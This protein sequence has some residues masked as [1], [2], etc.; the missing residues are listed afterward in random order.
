MQRLLNLIKRDI[1]HKKFM[2]NSATWTVRLLK[3]NPILA[4]QIIWSIRGG[5]CNKLS[6]SRNNLPSRLTAATTATA[7]VGMSYR[8]WEETRYRLRIEADGRPFVDLMRS[9][10][11]HPRYSGRRQKPGGQ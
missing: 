3:I 8:P 1:V 11:K 2:R 4:A 10:T 5:T 9:L 6:A 7:S